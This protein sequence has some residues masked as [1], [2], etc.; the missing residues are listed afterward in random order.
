MFQ[1]EDESQGCTGWSSIPLSGDCGDVLTSMMPM[2]AD[3]SPGLE[4]NEACAS[5]SEVDS[6]GEQLSLFRI[7]LMAS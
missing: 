7:K 6:V 3:D 1:L 5:D 4:L 2:V